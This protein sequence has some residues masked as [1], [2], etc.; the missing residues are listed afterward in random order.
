MNKIIQID[1]QELC[2]LL[3]IA[4]CECHYYNNML[5]II[6]NKQG[7]TETYWEIWQQ[8][9]SVLSNYNTFKEMIRVYYI[10]PEIG[11]NGLCQW[12]IDFYKK[13]ITIT[14]K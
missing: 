9:M 10:V 8:Y 12:S 2:E 14:Q 3:E 11:E 1:N 13:E 5:N 4:H 6:K 7:Y